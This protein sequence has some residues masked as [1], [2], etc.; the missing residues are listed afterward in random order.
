MVQPVQPAADNELDRARA[1]LTA[2]SL[3][4]VKGERVWR[5]AGRG[6]RPLFSLIEEVGPELAG[7]ALADTV[8]GKAAALLALYAGFAAVYA[9]ILSA[10]AQAV[11]QGEG[12]AVAYDRLVPNI[13]NREKS[14]LCPM[15]SLTLP[16]ADP[17]AAYQAVAAKLQA[18][19]TQKSE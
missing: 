8:V 15:E 11:L 10:P 16:L 12:L 2:S 14:G 18:W 17:A 3:V 4:A 7:A 6:I 13:L 19:E 9:R 1:L 5:K